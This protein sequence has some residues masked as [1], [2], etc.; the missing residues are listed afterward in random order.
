MRQHVNPLS[1]FFQLPKE[2]PSPS[3]LFLK[4]DQPLHLDL[5][6]ARGKFLLEMAEI[7]EDWN[8]LGLEIREVLVNSA[9]ADIEKKK[10]SNVQFI[11]CNAN[12]S[13]ESFSCKFP[14]GL[15]KRVSIHFPDPW[16]KRRHYKRRLLQPSLLIS[17]CKIL[18]TG[19]ELFIQ[20]DVLDVVN[21][22]VNLIEI[23]YCF[24]RYLM[25]DSL[26]SIDNPFLVRTE[27]EKYVL[28]KEF[29][30]YRARYKRNNVAPPPIKKLITF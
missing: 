20:S 8:F 17:L 4:P 30:I 9:I 29:P 26:L 7:H 23:S 14:K 2:V 6:S 15:L 24:D 28:N 5:G 12:N 10:L 19:S 22:M 21:Y 18:P 11:F 27:R 1:R 3:E 25:I 13:L 16:F